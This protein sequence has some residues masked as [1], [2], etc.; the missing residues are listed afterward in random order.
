MIVALTEGPGRFQEEF[1]EITRELVGY[2][3]ERY[4]RTQKQLAGDVSELMLVSQ[5]L[6]NDQQDNTN[7]EGRL[8]LIRS[9]LHKIWLKILSLVII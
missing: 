6:V 5:Q 2:D 1:N 7:Q 3:E 8:L 9:L 4:Q